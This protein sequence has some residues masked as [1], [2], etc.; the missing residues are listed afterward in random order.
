[1]KSSSQLN[2][3][4]GDNRID[5][6]TVSFYQM[7][8]E[9]DGFL[10]K[11]EVDWSL[12]NE[13]FSIPVEFQKS[14]QGHLGKVMRGQSK[15]IRFT[16][17]TLLFDAKVINQPFDEKKYAGH[18]DV[19]QVRYSPT[20]DL[21]FKLREI[22]EKSYAVLKALRHEA[23]KVDRRKQVRVPEGAREYLV[24]YAGADEQEIICDSITSDD[25][26]VVRSFVDDTDISEEEFERTGE[27]DLTDSG[28]R[29]ET[30]EQIVRIR[31]LDRSIG[32]SLKRVYK[33]RCQICAENFGKERGVDTAESHHIEAFV[34]SLNNDSD[35]LLV[36]CPNHHTVIHKAQPV[37]DRQRL[38]FAYANGFEEKLQLNIHLRKLG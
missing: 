1:M 30:R 26:A 31:R 5:S 6:G 34:K 20:S 38:R 16:V 18:P 7:P 22:F 17:G 25:I 24:L 35:N 33:Y 36:V 9:K 8:N 12:L 27:Y 13:G 37:F 21:A 15:K 10:Y 19:F 32:E 29:I 28:A 14:V 3:R 11:K 2:K 23:K 4:E